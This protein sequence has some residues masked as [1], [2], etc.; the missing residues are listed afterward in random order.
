MHRYAG[1]MSTS[2]LLHVTSTGPGICDRGQEC[3]IS[4]LV[5]CHMAHGHGHEHG[6]S[7]MELPDYKQWKIEGTPLETVQ[8]KL[9]AR[10]LRDPWGRNE[11][12]RYMGGFANNVSFVGALLKGFKWGFAAFVVAVG[13]E[14]YLESQKKDKKHH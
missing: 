10:G 4:P 13:A 8:E 2:S 12:W 3:L 11:A 6:P 5:S 1:K 14:Y 7:K 9:A